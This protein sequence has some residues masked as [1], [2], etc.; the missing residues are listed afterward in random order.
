M[1]LYPNSQNDIS[2][3]LQSFFF[4]TFLL[5]V[6]NPALA[7][8]TISENENGESTQ[9]RIVNLHPIGDHWNIG[10]LA[11]Y[12]DTKCSQKI[13][14]IKDV[15]F[16]INYDNH[17]LSVVH[18]NVCNTLGHANQ[19]TWAGGDRKPDRNTRGTWLGYEFTSPTEVQCVQ[20]CQGQENFQAVQEAALEYFNGKDWV[21]AGILKLKPGMSHSIRHD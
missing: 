17:E 20:V 21:N 4:L 11:M 3:I 10:E 13:K 12:T 6:S 1:P 2:N 19:G 7:D 15:L 8:T 18:D 5:A 16:S 9:W 14:S